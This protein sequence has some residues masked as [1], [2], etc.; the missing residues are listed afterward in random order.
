MERTFWAGLRPVPLSWGRAEQDGKGPTSAIRSNNRRIDLK[1]WGWISALSFNKCHTKVSKRWFT[2]LELSSDE[3]SIKPGINQ[4]HFRKLLLRPISLDSTAFKKKIKTNASVFGVH[5]T[6]IKLL[7]W[8]GSFPFFAFFWRL[9]LSASK[10]NSQRFDLEHVNEEH[11]LS[12]SKDLLYLYSV[13][14]QICLKI[15]YINRI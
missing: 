13:T 11:G 15:L 4:L 12:L 2:A 6:V 7:A 5:I 3:W 8:K 14:V 9:L 10:F 1:M